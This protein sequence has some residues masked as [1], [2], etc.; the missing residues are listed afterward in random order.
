[1]VKYWFFCILYKILLSWDD[2]T[3]FGGGGVGGRKK[4]LEVCAVGG[5][6]VFFLYIV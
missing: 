2:L 4:W 1:M 6:K 3:L 5:F